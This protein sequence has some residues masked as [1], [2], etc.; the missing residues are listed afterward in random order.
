MSVVEVVLRTE[1]V[2]TQRELNMEIATLEAK[3]IEAQH[4]IAGRIASLDGYNKDSQKVFV[5]RN[6]GSLVLRDN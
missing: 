6:K 3:Y 5:S 1:N 4:V 2:Q